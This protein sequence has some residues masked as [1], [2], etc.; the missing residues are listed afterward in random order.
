MGLCCGRTFRHFSGTRG[1]MDSNMWLLTVAMCHYK[2]PGF[3]LASSAFHSYVFH[4]SVYG[5]PMFSGLARHHLR[6]SRA[7]VPRCA[8]RLMMSAHS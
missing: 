8:C 3:V 1:K 7:P 4:S 5:I 6:L 2:A